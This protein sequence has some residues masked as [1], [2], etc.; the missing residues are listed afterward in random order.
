MRWPAPIALCGL[1]L[2]AGCAPM[3]G[4]SAPQAA[5]NPAFGEPFTLQA[6]ETAR[7]GSDRV[8][9]TFDA[10]VSDSRC[11]VDVQ[12]IRA[13]EAVVRVSVARGD[14]APGTVELATAPNRDRAAVGEYLLA[15]T[16][17]L[18]EPNTTV[19]ITASD[20]RAT[21]VLSRP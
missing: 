20:Y 16:R 6:G 17:V 8:G 3:V 11:P 19:R 21:F 15:L 18:P 13:G 1:T 10:V 12:C 14:Q 7:V 4:A 2:L 9:V 5:A